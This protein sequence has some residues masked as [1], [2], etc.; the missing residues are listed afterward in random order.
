MG[1]NPTL[2]IILLFST[3]TVVGILLIGV[4]FL[5][6]GRIFCGIGESLRKFTFDKVR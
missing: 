4:F 1:S 5:G 6:A 3:I 2:F